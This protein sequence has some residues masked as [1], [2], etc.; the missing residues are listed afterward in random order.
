MESGAASTASAAGYEQGDVLVEESVVDRVPCEN[1]A[2][3]F[4]SG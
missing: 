1:A 2:Y 4:D 3:R